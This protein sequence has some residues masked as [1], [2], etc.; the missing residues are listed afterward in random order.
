MIPVCSPVIG[1]EEVEAVVAA[2]KRGEISGAFG[3]SLPR[4]EQAFAD[5]CGC[6]H[7]VAVSSGTAAL[8]V[9][10]AAAG[11]GPGDE[12]LVSAST[13]IATALGVYHCGAVPV[14]VDSE[15]RTWNLNL[16][17]IESL[18]TE[19]TRAIVPVH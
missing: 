6:A 16:D 2:L 17:L 13:N 12:V 5:Y 11:I 1:P 18:I 9:S 8:H 10:V 15:P 7:G 14:P 19:R 3:E 4:F